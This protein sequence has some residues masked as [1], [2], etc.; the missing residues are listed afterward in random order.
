M[1]ELD[2]YKQTQV[3]GES[4]TLK[5]HATESLNDMVKNYS[6]FME[7][8]IPLSA[9]VKYYE[10]IGQPPPIELFPVYLE[11]SWRELVI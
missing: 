8:L 9:I 3:K 4:K 2:E 7:G 11:H 1:L 6:K 10:V 5:Y